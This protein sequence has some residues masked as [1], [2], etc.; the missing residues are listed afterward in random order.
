MII[1]IDELIRDK[2]DLCYKPIDYLNIEDKLDMYCCHILEEPIYQTI[3]ISISYPILDRTLIDN[4]WD[5]GS[6]N[7]A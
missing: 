6:V 2:F 5:M 4:I 7:R 1:M 3:T